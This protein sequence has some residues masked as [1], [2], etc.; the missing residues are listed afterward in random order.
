MSR[1]RTTSQ[2]KANNHP[3]PGARTDQRAS[4]GSTWNARSS[5]SEASRSDRY[6]V[7]VTCATR[8]SATNLLVAR[9]IRYNVSPRSNTDR[10]SGE[11]ARCSRTPSPPRTQRAVRRARRRWRHPERRHMSNLNRTFTHSRRPPGGVTDPRRQRSA[12][13]PMEERCHLTP[14]D[15]LAR[16]EL[17]I[18][19]RVAAPRDPSSSRL[20]N[21]GFENRPV[22]INKCVAA[23]VISQPPNARTMKAAIWAQV[24][25][26]SGQYSV[27]VR[28]RPGRS[29]LRGCTQQPEDGIRPAIFVAG[30]RHHLYFSAGV[31]ECSGTPGYGKHGRLSQQVERPGH[32]YVALGKF[33]HQFTDPLAQIGFIERQID[34][35]SPEG[36]G[37]QSSPRSRYSKL[38]RGTIHSPWRRSISA[39]WSQPTTS[40]RDHRAQQR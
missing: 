1:P 20:G 25:A 30:N 36:I 22:I 23:T 5:C 6:R 14:C 26:L 32:R 31:A 34:A 12:Q 27:A 21:S 29:V 10:G 33:K 40:Q 19:R 35:A 39:G 8:N 7:L 9:R 28:C 17:I 38:M 16:T 2:L 4:A 18:H 13:C 3:S 15:C 24:T 11:F 37:I